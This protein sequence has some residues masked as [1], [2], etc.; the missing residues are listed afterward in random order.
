MVAKLSEALGHST[1]WQT[2]RKKSR[3][4]LKGVWYDNS[5]HQ[6]SEVSRFNHFV[7]NGLSKRFKIIVS[8]IFTTQF[9]LSQCSQITIEISTI[10]GTIEIPYNYYYHF[11]SKVC[12]TC[13]NSCAHVHMHKF[14]GVLQSIDK[15]INQLDTGAGILQLYIYI[16]VNYKMCFIH[17]DSLHTILVLR[18]F[19]K[20]NDTFVIHKD[21]RES[22][23]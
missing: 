18:S 1:N 5:Q 16:P 17:N 14:I 12:S 23:D 15:S 19:Q 4:A 8:I 10:G 9:F 22:K 3:I 20:L 6:K 2:T 21:F 11:C 7:C 13:T